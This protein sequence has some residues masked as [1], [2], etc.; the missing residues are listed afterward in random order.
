MRD[1]H[2][3]GVIARAPTSA[4]TLRSLF[5][6]THERTNA[7][8]VRLTGRS[9]QNS[10]RLLSA[11]DQPDS[12]GRNSVV[13]NN[14][15]NEQAD[16]EVGFNCVV[17][18]NRF[19][20]DVDIAS[21]GKITDSQFDAAVETGNAA[22]VS[23]THSAGATDI[24]SGA[25]VDRVTAHQALEIAANTHV[26]QCVFKGDTDIAAGTTLT[27]V[28]ADDRLDVAANT[29]ISGS[30]FRG[31]TEVSA[32]STIIDALFESTVDL[33]ANTEIHRAGE[34]LHF[35]G[36][37]TLNTGVKLND[38]SQ[39]QLASISIYDAASGM[40]TFAYDLE[41]SR[42][43]GNFRIEKT[44]VPLP[45]QPAPMPTQMPAAAHPTLQPVTPPPTALTTPPSPSPNT[46]VASASPT[47]SPTAA[48]ESYTA[49]TLLG[50]TYSTIPVGTGPALA[51]LYLQIT[52][53]RRSIARVI[54]RCT[55]PANPVNQR[56]LAI[57]HC[58]T[59]SRVKLK[60]MSMP[61]DYM[62]AKG[63]YCISTT[64]PT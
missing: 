28:N 2:P 22:T 5:T 3:R 8:T 37:V 47:A 62:S 19:G 24:A 40:R 4:P 21:N 46:P 41:I 48:P 17:K 56:P 26:T 51:D 32:G 7:P 35:L 20:D 57:C 33:A 64:G 53:L 49:N 42:I 23:H 1:S 60:F 58:N 36:D 63:I 39:D 44:R 50:L 38:L 14:E 34:M 13:S 12:V 18:N 45:A 61:F 29:Q 10:A 11:S 55:I 52:R 25:T 6:T 54:S 43:G 15:F 30:T 9:L 16:T 27:Q 31:R 59:L